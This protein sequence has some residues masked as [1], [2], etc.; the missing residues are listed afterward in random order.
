MVTL[1]DADRRDS[2]PKFD[3]YAQDYGFLHQQSVRFS[4]EDVEYFAR[5]KLDC[6]TRLGA[7]GPLLDFGCGV[8]NVTKVLGQTF[9]DVTGYDPSEDSLRLARQRVPRA[10]FSSDLGSLKDGHFGVVV[11]A[12][13]LHHI[14]PAERDP[15]LLNVRRKLRPRGRIVIFEHNPNN[16]VTRRA[17]RDCPFDDDAV[18]LPA[19]EV[20]ERLRRAGFRAVM[21]DYIVFFPKVLSLLRPLEPRLRRVAL[22]AQTMTTAVHLPES[23]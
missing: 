18:L 8:G 22:G 4:G 3:A 12:G 23:G 17:V 1:P 5:Y 21:Q 2:A 11:L 13:V 10:R 14:L 6:L 7:E 16:P 19:A 15:V 20:R 9:A